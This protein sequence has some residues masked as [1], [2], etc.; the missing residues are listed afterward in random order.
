MNVSTWSI[1]RPVPALLLFGL[2]TLLGIG[3]FRALPI[4]NFPDIDV[5]VVT[6]SAG[7]EGAAPAQLETE[8]ARKLEDAVAALGGIEHVRTTITDGMVAIR[9]EFDIDKDSE[10]A[11]NEVRNAVDA[12]RADLPADLR[13]PVVSRIT[14]AGGVA[15]FIVRSDRLDEAALSWFVDNDVSKALLAVRGVGRVSRQGG[16]DREVQVELDPVRM[17]SLGVTAADIS[18]RLREVQRD[19]S[20]GRGDIGGVVQSVRTL[21]AVGTAAELAALDIPV[22]GGRQIR[23][24]RI[25][26]VR[27]G[28]AERS[29][30]ALADGEQV[31]AFTVMR[32]RGAS[33]VAVAAGVRQALDRL[34]AAQPQVQITE[35]YNNVDP[36]LDNYRGSMEL[37]FEGAALAVLVV[38][39]FL[40]D[41]RATVI[42]AIALPLSVLPTFLVMQ[43][44]GFS[45]NVL[46]L[47][48]LALVVGILVDDAIVEV[49]NIVRHLR[50]GKSPID[51]AID[52]ADE[53]GLAVIATSLTLVA[54]FLPTAF[55]GGIPGRFF[56]QFGITTA[57]AVAASLL[58][59]R[60]LTPMMS[61]YGLKAHPPAVSDSRLMGAYLASTAWCLRHRV[62]TTLGVA[63][64]FI[65]SVALIPLLPTG[66]VPAADRD[67]TSVNLELAPG[68]SLEDTRAAAL[69]AQ[70]LLAGLNE[71]TRVF[72]VVGSSAG[73][74]GP[75][76]GGGGSDVRKAALT[77]S[78]VH[79]TDRARTQAAMEGVIRETL[80]NVPGARVSVGG[81]H[82]GEKL[83][84]TLASDDPIALTT[85]SQ[86]VLADLRSLPGIGN[87]TSLASLQRPEIHVRP[88]RQRSAELGVTAQGLAAAMRLASGG[89]FAAALPKLNLPSRQ[90]PIRVRL[91]PAFRQDLAAISA[92]DVPTARGGIP[93]GSVAEVGLG[94]GPAQIDRLD[95]MRTV[96]LDIE[97]AGRALGT[98][99]NEANLLPSLVNLPP[100][101]SRSSAGDAE[102]MAELFGRFGTAMLI[103]ILCIYIVL[104]L[105][106]HDFLQPITILAALPL[107]AGGAFV[108]LL[109]TNN[110]I[111]MPSVIGLLM[112]MGIVTKNSI[113]LVEYALMSRRVHGLERGAALL[114]ACHKRARPILMTTIAM[115]A[116][117]LPVALGLGAEPSFRSPMAIVVIGGLITSTVLSLL[118]IPVLFTYVDDLQVWLGRQGLGRA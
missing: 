109:S 15:T 112:L 99:L 66:F 34:R 71:V 84:I 106:F 40:R 82:S 48:A 108:A 97:L 98:V 45:L 42:S 27:D 4:Q 29:S 7:L 95:R 115:T 117:M 62:L 78:L 3:A 54:V 47:L 110:S 39:W 70:R 16:I 60:L 76:D 83:T 72:I 33:E 57:T 101:V 88:D 38:F 86:A 43:W 49:E 8:V 87:V 58:V 44:C 75:L 64:F 35:A 41:W 118:V 50:M 2:L 1:R 21:A 37:L 77:V 31:V 116:G 22:S 93:I 90:V 74:G 13:D 18:Q 53:I 20:G 113:L 56:I 69:T 91:A 79:R 89:D 19:A 26:T 51:A 92:L 104:V 24:D 68:S 46:T 12:V 105:L 114:D 103:G 67:Q 94:S 73:G 17:A 32:T 10:I 65:G 23:L 52:A 61:A 111:S 28:H 14:T 107:S 96:S 6:I 25:A 80:R 81:L 100:G 85:A 55:M 36:V 11:L 59:A 9:V 102:R 30:Y 5:P 63:A